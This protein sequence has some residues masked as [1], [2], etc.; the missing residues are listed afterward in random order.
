M[1]SSTRSLTG[2]DKGRG[3]GPTL[4]IILEPALLPR[5]FPLLQRGFLV[6]ARLEESIR[7]VL[8]GQL[9]LSAD[10]VSRRVSTIFLDGKP[11]DDLDSA[12]IREGSTLALSC[13]MPGLVGATMR[14]EGFYASFRSSITHKEERPRAAG[15]EGLFRV[16]LFNLLM[17]ELGPLFLEKGIYLQ[18]NE[19]E[20]FFREEADRLLG[21][22]AKILLDGQSL[23]RSVPLRPGWAGDDLVRLTVCASP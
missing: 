21:G 7:E 4:S 20:G 13:A 6:K 3:R 23:P 9:G 19:A 1:R 17:G 18:P 22:S 8:C 11:V 12:V 14:R 16:K 10:Y 5:F 2:S 15:K